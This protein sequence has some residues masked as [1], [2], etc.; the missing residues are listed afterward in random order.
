MECTKKEIVVEL[1]KDLELDETFIK[2]YVNETRD[3]LFVI[4]IDEREDRALLTYMFASDS[5]SHREYH[6]ERMG[7]EAWIEFCM[8]VGEIGGMWATV[9]AQKIKKIF[10]LK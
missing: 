1:D 7:K 10:E 9:I 2:V 3:N 5:Y 6:A 8:R 4:F